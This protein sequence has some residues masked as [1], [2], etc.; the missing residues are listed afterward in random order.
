MRCQDMAF[1]MTAAGGRG[2][3]VDAVVAGIS[4]IRVRCIFGHGLGH[5]VGLE[6]SC[7]PFRR[8]RRRW[9]MMVFSMEPGIYVEN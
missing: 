6:Y 8:R 1:K 3:A 4:A 7:L 5:G 9:E 2:A